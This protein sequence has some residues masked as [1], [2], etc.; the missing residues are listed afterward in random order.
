[1]SRGVKRCSLLVAAI[2]ATAFACEGP[3]GPEGPPGTNG[4]PG[5]AGTNGQSA[6]VA[7]TAEAAGANCVNGGTKVEVGLDANGNGVLDPS[8][9]NAAATSYV[10]DGTDGT[11]GDPGSVGADGHDTL[12]ATTDEP[13]GANCADGGIKIESGVDLDD[14]GTLDPTE[15]NAAA[16]RFVCDGAGGL[17]GAAGVSSASTGLHVAVVD[18]STTSPVTVRFT[19]KDDR[20]FPV[21]IAGVY[22]VNTVMA[23]RFALAYLVQD[24]SGKQLPPEVLTK[25]TSTSNPAAQPT[26]F[27]STSA[28]AGTVVENGWGA[29]DYTYTFPTVDTASPGPRAVA[30]DP[31][32]LDRTHVVWI[33]AA[34]QT[35]LEITNDAATFTPVNEAYYF[36]PSGTGT[37]ATREIVTQANCS[38]CHQG[39]EAEGSTSN[40]FHGAGRVDVQ[41]CVICHNPDRTNAAADAM[42]FVHRLHKSSQIQEAN[43][44]HGLEF[45]FPQ[46]IRNCDACHGG[47]AQGNQIRTRPT[48]KACGS[49]HDYTDFAGT[50]GLPLCTNPVTKGADGLPAPCRHLGG[51]QTDDTNCAFCHTATAIANVHTPVAPPDPN[52]LWAG[53]TSSNT[54]AAYVAAAGVVPAGAKVIT[55]DVSTV[56]LVDDATITPNK[57]LQIKFK[58][59]ADGTDVVFQTPGAGVTEIMAGFVGSPSVYFAYALPQDDI[60]APADFNVSASGYIKKIWDGTATGTA[61]GTITGPDGSGYYTI[62][63]T[64][65]QVPPSATLLTGGVGYSYSLSSAPPL[66][67]IDLAAYPYNT[68]TKQGGLI[69]PAPNVWKVATGFTGRRAIVDNAKCNACHG[70]LGVAP[71]FHAGQRN[72]GPTCSFCHTPNRTSS[73]WSASSKLFIHAVHAGRLRDVEFN[74][75]APAEGE[76]YGEIEFPAPLSNCEASCHVAGTYD[77]SAT[78]SKSAL[79]NLLM[80]TV[81]TGRYKGTAALNPTGWFSISPY[82]VSDNTVDYGF[83]FATSNVTLSLPDGNSGTQGATICTPAAPCICTTSSP[84][85]VVSTVG[86]QGATTCTEAAPCTCTTASKCTV[87]VKTCSVGAPCDPDPTTLV[88]SPITAACVGCHDSPMVVDHY[89]S[90]GGAF[91]RSR[92]EVLD[93]DAPV[94][95]CLLC[96]AKG[97]LAGIGAM[98][99]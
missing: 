67:Q 76:T 6:V 60:D 1:M 73:G 81:G 82:V 38:K 85:E 30:Y 92:G 78:A 17:T 47:A 34:R 65:A 77:L 4:N 3:A 86:V 62:K 99:K 56:E 43:L 95:Q 22:S 11:P 7:T 53:G 20:G 87:T 49:C 90:N 25:S 79:P 48:A 51:P 10:C 96:H 36:I 16:T 37:V 26:A 9:V 13:A 88:M 21:D 64:G 27:N 80:T 61:A 72:D 71:T 74:W 46:E 69:V 63:L 84:C 14:S 66:T 18:V 8:E 58:L 15:V 42:V 59:K 5:T 41:F 54:N 32:Q 68:G 91:Y 52:N 94:E 45:E 23:P 19:L 24:A 28:G 98:H 57:R 55:Y 12:V 83:N 33:Q 70:L 29:G 2:A 75:H 89:E 44:F 31:A 39:F 97:K 93:A 40:G 50:A 35:N